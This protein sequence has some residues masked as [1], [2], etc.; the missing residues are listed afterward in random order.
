MGRKTRLTPEIQQQV[1]TAI[2]SGNWQEIACEYAGIHPATYY[3]WLERGQA[4]IERLEGDDD[5]EPNEEETPYREFCEAV[6]KA[7]AVS[8][9]QAVGLIR[10]AAVDGSWQAAGWYLER[11]HPKRWAKVDKLEHTGR[12]GAPIQM[13]NVSVAD[14]ESEIK[15]LLEDK[16]GTGLVEPDVDGNA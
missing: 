5:A 8:E 3:R 15:I 2:S 1:V 9:V 11:S 10:K 6:R 13:M 4:E 14:L 7:Q 12:E 16:R